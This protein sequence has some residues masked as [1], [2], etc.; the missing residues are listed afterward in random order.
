[1]LLKPFMQMGLQ[2]LLFSNTISGAA[3]DV[4]DY[5]F[6]N[7][8]VLLFPNPAKNNIT[9][10]LGSNL[11]TNKPIEIYNVLGKKVITIK[12]SDVVNGSVTQNITSLNSGMYFMKISVNGIH[13]NRKFI[14]N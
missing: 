3:L 8:E 7:D 10:Q 14:V 11:Q 9:I 1:M 4:T 13:I 12:S 5:E 2:M 6:I